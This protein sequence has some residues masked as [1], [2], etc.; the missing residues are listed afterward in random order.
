M[1][2]VFKYLSFI[3]ALICSTTVNA[4]NV[5][6]QANFSNESKSKD[7]PYY[8]SPEINT[9]VE[10]GSFKFTYKKSVAHA[11]KFVSYYP[12][13]NSSFSIE[14]TVE[15]LKG[16][17]NFGYGIVFGAKDV[18][19]LYFFGISGNGNFTLYSFSN[20]KY[21]NILNWQPS[22]F[23]YR[24]QGFKNKLKVEKRSD[25]IY[26]FINNQPVANLVAPIFFGDNCGIMVQM[27]Q[28]IGFN[29]FTITSNDSN[30]TALTPADDNIGKVAY[31]TTFDQD[32]ENDWVIAAKDSVRMAMENSHLKIFNSSKNI[33]ISTVTVA[34]TW[35]DMNRDFLLET[36]TVYYSGKGETGFG[37]VFGL[38]TKQSYQFFI[39]NA[40]YFGFGYSSANGYRDLVPWK[41][42]TA[43]N[44]GINSKNKLT[45][46]RKE[47]KILFYIN[48][49]LVYTHGDIGFSGYQ[50]GLIA[51]GNQTVGY[52]Y[53]TFKYLDNKIS[54][55]PNKQIAQVDNKV[56]EIKILSP[57]VTRGLKVVSAN[58]G[59]KVTG[60]ANDASL[61]STVTI[62]GIAAVLGT[63]GT[64]SAD[65]PLKTGDNSL[66][67]VATDEFRNQGNY[68]FL[69]EKPQV[70]KIVETSTANV[71]GK[72]YALIIG[73]EN[74]ADDK[75]VDLQY[76]VSDATKLANTLKT[77]YNFEEQ[78][79]N[80]LK[81]PTR[82]QVFAA[83]EDLIT[84]VKPED[85]VLIFYAGHG[86]W[87]DSRQ[88]GFWFPSDAQNGSRPTYVSNADLKEYIS[89][90]KSKHTLLITD[91]C[92]AGSIFKTRSVLANAPKAISVLY[93]LPSRKAM[94][95]GALK[96][97]PD[98]SIFVE[99]LLK[100]LNQNTEKYLSAEDLFS[101]LKIA[102][103]NNSDTD[104][105]PMYGEIKSAGDEGGDF[106][107]IK[108]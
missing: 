84:K 102:V 16:V 95:S 70:P 3:I 20:G 100:R 86:L 71:L 42:T 74:Y 31:S 63:D 68:T 34:A 91:A 69:V 54:V 61:I 90:I 50:F 22:N 49:I 59:I 89:S 7:W 15:H 96:E 97:V 81:N 73:V 1:Y 33:N 10:D 40:G 80:L 44:K 47:G 29:S 9:K 36:S 21:T 57:E 19:N 92:F 2:K 53:I 58:D 77:V 88:E 14:T 24:S 17:D 37:V 75:I 38:D 12:N 66:T 18:N 45:I 56:P 28:T 107:F 104:Q 46:L 87:M 98:K 4:Q 62:N 23:I 27:N 5:L 60:I 8:D 30:T 39:A 85:N 41:E 67:V 83:L 103:M 94:T 55:N 101:K 82:L 106:I 25:K 64:F 79:T 32:D 48:D 105:T 78:N 13:K 108:R 52:D 99:Y 6:Y 65:V 76:P 11:A 43:V 35:V 93:D 26:L 72:Y 51:G